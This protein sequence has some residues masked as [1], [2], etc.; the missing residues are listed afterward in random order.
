MATFAQPTPDEN[1][2][3]GWT[4]QG[5]GS[6]QSTTGIPG[7]GYAQGATVPVA[8]ALA[9][10]SPGVILGAGLPQPQGALNIGAENSGSQTVSILSNPGYA[11]GN[12][13]IVGF[14]TPP[15]VPASTVAAQNP[16][17]LAA[18]VT[19]TGGTTTFIFTAPLVNGAAGTYTQVGTTTP[20]TVTVPPAGFIKITYSGAPTWVWTTTN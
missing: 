2:S 5:T 14:L 1:L 20:Q 9:T 17:G 4:S 13:T 7:A 3:P 10:S 11:D 8:V 12:G 18:I 16:S 15:T 6:A 19:I